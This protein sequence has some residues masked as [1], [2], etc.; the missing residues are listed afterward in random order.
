MQAEH[1]LTSTG[2]DLTECE[3]PWSKYQSGSVKRTT[4]QLPLHALHALI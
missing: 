3:E 1:N 2:L 4:D